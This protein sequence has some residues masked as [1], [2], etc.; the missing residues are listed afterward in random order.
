MKG[1]RLKLIDVFLK[2]LKALPT[3]VLSSTPGGTA[4]ESFT[5]KLQQAGLY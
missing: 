3:F 1:S 5:Y 2:I 4:F